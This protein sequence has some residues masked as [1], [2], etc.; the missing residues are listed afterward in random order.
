MSVTI[1]GIT[2]EGNNIK[3]INDKVWIDGKRLDKDNV[4]P[5]NNILKVE[6][7][8]NLHN[9]YAGGSVEVKGNVYGDVD[10]GGSVH[11]GDVGKD[12]DAGGSVHAGDVAGDIDAG[13]SVRH[14]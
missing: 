2:Y 6:V 14:G 13:G 9:L 4:K 5:S 8:G 1:N 3:V 7:T 10:A 12:V 11:C